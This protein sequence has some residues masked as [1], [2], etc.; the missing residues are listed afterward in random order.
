[1]SVKVDLTNVANAVREGDYRDADDHTT[2][3]LC[4]MLL[5]LRDNGTGPGMAALY[6]ALRTS[7]ESAVRRALTRAAFELNASKD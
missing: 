7:P 5:L 1:M 4:A 6:A 2:R 3:A